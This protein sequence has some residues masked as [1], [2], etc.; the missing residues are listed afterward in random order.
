MQHY[1]GDKE[2]LLKRIS[3]LERNEHLYHTLFNEMDSGFLLAKLIYDE[4]GTPYDAKFINANPATEKH[5]GIKPEDIINKSS[6]EVFNDLN[7]S[8]YLTFDQILKSKQSKTFERFF[9]PLDKWLEIHLFSPFEGMF[10]CTFIDISNRIK[11]KKESQKRANR[12]NSLLK[13]SKAI[14]E[15]KDFKDQ[16][17]KIFEEAKNLVG[18]TSGYIALLSSDG[19]N[20]DVLFLDSGDLECTVDPEL[21]MPI[22]GLRAEAYKLKKPRYNNDFMNSDWVKFMPKGHVILKNVLF[23]PL[24]IKDVDHA[25]GLLGIANKPKDFTDEDAE[26]II[27]FTELISIALY[28]SNI[29]SKLKENENRLRGIIDNS[30]DAISLIN[31]EGK[32]IEWNKAAENIT[33]IKKDDA[34]NYNIWNLRHPIKCLQTKDTTLEILKK[35]ASNCLGKTLELEYHNINKQLCNAQSITFP[36]KTDQG[37]ML[38]TI[39][40]D[41]TEKKK[42][43]KDLKIKTFAVESSVSPVIFSDL[44]GRI[45]YLNKAALNFWKYNSKNE[46]IS[47]HITELAYSERDV[48]QIMN[49]VINRTNLI[50]EGTPICK[51]GTIKHVLYSINIIKNDDKIPVGLMASFQ[52]IS[53]RV[54]YENELKNAK[55]KAEKADNLKSVF[56]ANVSHDIRTPLNGIL[57][58]ANILMLKYENN[59][60]LQFDINIIK[61]SGKHLLDLINNILDLSRL[62]AKQ[63][64]IS[65]EYE[66]LSK[67]IELLYNTSMNIINEKQK[68]ISINL[69]IDENI[70]D[71]IYTDHTKLNQIL[72]NL[73]GN[74]IKFSDN[75]IINLDIGLNEDYLEFC[76]SDQGIGIPDVQLDY[77]FQAFTRLKSEVNEKGTGL[78]LSITKKL[79]E[80]LEGKISVESE[81]GKGSSFKFTIPYIFNTDGNIK[82]NNIVIKSKNKSYKKHTILV[83]EDH[84]ISQEIIKQILLKLDCKPIFANNAKECLSIYNS[85]SNIDLI[86][87]DIAL[88]D[89]DGLELTRKI[90]YS[91]QKSL[92]KKIPIIALSAQAMKD[93]INKG[94]EAGCDDYITKPYEISDISQILNKYL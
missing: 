67:M 71:I 17:K 41:I 61:R 21:P 16:A 10:A 52:D 32:I 33:N 35:G 13:A 85:N 38:G 9:E 84:L 58:M 82:N 53:D 57:G 78:G 68:S 3:E 88:P 91:E 43:E 50:S 25:V 59:K 18:A 93:D 66:S 45:T 46:L 30:N 24:F 29:L 4:N 54:K 34:T 48:S 5:L 77:I 80:L 56:L 72:N 76:I 64:E 28:N 15:Y 8:W 90:R 39:T 74:A 12:I 22:R 31:E 36:I 92:R 27:S 70:N 81:F 51:D 83:V 44:N 79:V 40:R 69:N 42:I 1:K 86:F 37:F 19:K 73:M 47:K 75:G 11:I 23:A 63:M 7:P 2:K 60:E 55:E 6:N 20:N 89:I 62:E 26:I 14:L 65:N 87:M 94:F 49:C